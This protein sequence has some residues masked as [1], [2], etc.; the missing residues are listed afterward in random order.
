MW[1]R[2]DLLRAF[3]LQWA[4]EIVVPHELNAGRGDFNFA[5][6]A[7]ADPKYSSAWRLLP[8][9]LK[10]DYKR[11]QTEVDEYARACQ[12]LQES[13]ETA[14]TAATGMELVREQHWSVWP[15]RVLDTR[16][17]ASIMEEALGLYRDEYEIARIAYEVTQIR[18]GGANS[19]RPM[20]KLYAT[21]A[22]FAQRDLAYADQAGD[23][24]PVSEQHRAL[25]DRARNGDFA[26]LVSDIAER[27]EKAGELLEQV[28]SGLHRLSVE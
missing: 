13:I 10:S 1:R 20:S 12:T 4:A 19:Q 8:R 28:Q 6:R 21:Y 9:R 24:G 18:F 23:L 17:P 26:G 3:V 27:K 22:G 2:R 11:L 25:M 5:E 7:E 16:F 14:C 15:A